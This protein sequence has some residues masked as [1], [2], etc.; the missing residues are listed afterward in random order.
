M[1]AARDDV[2]L[3]RQFSNDDNM[4]AHSET[5]GP[6]SWWQ[7]RFHS[8]RPDAFVAGVGTGLRRVMQRGRTLVIAQIDTRRWMLNQRVHHLGVHRYRLQALQQPASIL[9]LPTP[10]DEQFTGARLKATENPQQL[11]QISVSTPS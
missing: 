3:P 7:L 1:A 9:G 4:S 5:T 2:F 6:E 11:S 8:L 10:A